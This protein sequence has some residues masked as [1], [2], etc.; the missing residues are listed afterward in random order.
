MFKS[1]GN[2]ELG[3]LL[4]SVLVRMKE[5][6]G[7]SAEA[8]QSWGNDC[9]QGGRGDMKTSP[10]DLQWRDE[11]RAMGGEQG[12]A[13]QRVGQFRAKG[14]R[15]GGR[16]LQGIAGMLSLYRLRDL[17]LRDATRHS[18]RAAVFLRH[19]KFQLEG[20]IKVDDLISR[21]PISGA[22]FPPISRTKPMWSFGYSS[23]CSTR[24]ATSK[25]TSLRSTRWYFAKAV[26]DAG[27]KPTSSASTVRY[28]IA[29]RRFSSSKPP[30]QLTMCAAF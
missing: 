17:A 7:K 20:K 10:L 27:P 30:P 18:G 23:R 25:P 12:G 19:D 13:L 11:R 16:R 9:G 4:P 6:C 8:A 24:L 3:E 26:S 15:A 14:F 29:I 22:I 21:C 2:Y 28:A 1:D 5:L